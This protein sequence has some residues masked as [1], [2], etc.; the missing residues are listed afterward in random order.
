MCPTDQLLSLQ[1]KLILLTSSKGN[2]GTKHLLGAIK[3]LTGLGSLAGPVISAPIDA[4]VTLSPRK[5]PVF[6][7]QINF[8]VS[9]IFPVYWIICLLRVQ[10]CGEVST[11][12]KGWLHKTAKEKTNYCQV[13]W[14]AEWESEREFIKNH[15]TCT[16][17]RAT[18]GNWLCWN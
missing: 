9:N 6:T 1:N 14:A 7:C 11:S 17:C 5:L 2:G 13:C 3:P 18:T 8:P 15:V 16:W 10:G 12:G 4:F